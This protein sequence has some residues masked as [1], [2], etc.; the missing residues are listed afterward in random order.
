MYSES[1]PKSTEAQERRMMEIARHLAEDDELVDA[2]VDLEYFCIAPYMQKVRL[3]YDE[4]LLNF[5]KRC[6][7]AMRPIPQ[8]AEQAGYLANLGR[9]LS[10]GKPELDPFGTGNAVAYTPVYFSANRTSSRIYLGDVVKVRYKWVRLT[11]TGVPGTK[12]GGMTLIREPASLAMY[13]PSALHNLGPVV[14]ARLAAGGGI[15]MAPQILGYYA[16]GF[17]DQIIRRKKLI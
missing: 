4:L 5:Y 12:T 11:R 2:I 10:L 6:T 3:I 17:H 8:Y 15:T 1:L 16:C 14:R 7:G 9:H 13:V